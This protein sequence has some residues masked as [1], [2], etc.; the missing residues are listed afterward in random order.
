MQGFLFVIFL[1]VCMRVCVLLWVCFVHSVFFCLFFFFLATDLYRV[2]VVLKV[3]R[4]AAN[5][6][7]RGL[8]PGTV[9]HVS[10]SVLEQDTEHQIAFDIDLL[11]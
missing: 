2:S 7:V 9:V 3:E 1:C 8:I 10:P 5:W 6:K 11:V 4:S